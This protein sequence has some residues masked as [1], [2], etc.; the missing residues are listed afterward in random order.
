M[1]KQAS[2]SVCLKPVPV[3]SYI[4][5]DPPGAV[6]LPGQLRPTPVQPQRAASLAAR[7]PLQPGQRLDPNTA[8]AQELAR[9]PG[10][11][12]RL[13]KEIVAD[14]EIRGLFGSLEA[15]DRVGWSEWARPFGL[16]PALTAQVASTLN[17][18]FVVPVAYDRLAQ[19][20]GSPGDTR[21]RL[22]RELPDQD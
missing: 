12:M 3:I 7:R 14:R 2:V 20:S 5:Q 11:G 8:S 18:L 13:A 6:L 1:V 19:H 4:P 21:R 16:P 17:A 15:L 22:E 9:I 10:L